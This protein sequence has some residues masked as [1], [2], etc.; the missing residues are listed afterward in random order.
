MDFNLF[1]W[2]A[3]IV[4]LTVLLFVLVCWPFLV[5]VVET[6]GGIARRIVSFGQ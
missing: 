6:V 1:L 3:I 4:I 5:S 2:V